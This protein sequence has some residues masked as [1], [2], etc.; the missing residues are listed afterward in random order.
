MS[1]RYKLYNIQPEQVVTID[2]I[3]DN[4]QPFVEEIAGGL[5]EHNFAPDGL[6]RT[7]F[8]DDTA[9]VVHTSQANDVREG[10]VGYDDPSAAN[11]VTIQP[12]ETWQTFPD[13]GL[14]VTFTTKATTLYLC[15]SFNI[16]CGT[17]WAN[18]G[19]PANGERERIYK[20]LGFGYLVAIRLDGTVINETILGSGDAGVDD[21]QARDF[22]TGDGT[23]VTFG[24]PQGGGGIAGARLPLTVDAVVEA[25]PGEHTVDVVVMNIK[26]SMRTAASLS[27]YIGQREIFALELVR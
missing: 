18:E 16:H 22:V 13:T 7:H 19:G 2:P 25:L 5:N 10:L 26:G 23:S 9:L 8:A 17:N 12:V 4:F 11:W 15:A 3:N 21:F 27:T 24:R 14:T 6:D 1:W 20:Q